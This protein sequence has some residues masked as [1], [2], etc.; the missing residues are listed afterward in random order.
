MDVASFT[1]LQRRDS[2][3]CAPGL[4]MSSG[5]WQVDVKQNCF[6]PLIRIIQPELQYTFFFELQRPYLVFKVPATP[7]FKKAERFPTAAFSFHRPHIW[8]SEEGFHLTL[9]RYADFGRLSQSPLFQMNERLGRVQ[10]TW[11]TPRKEA[12]MPEEMGF[13][14]FLGP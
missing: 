7:S 6:L 10:R 11:T 8:W 2:H 4:G 5:F 9:P 13:P 12:Y 14:D 1:P 3:F